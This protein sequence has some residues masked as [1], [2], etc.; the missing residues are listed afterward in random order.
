MAKAYTGPVCY[1]DGW[2]WTATPAGPGERLVLEDDGSYRLATAADQSW[3]D[4]H[5]CECCGEPLV[6][7]DGGA[8]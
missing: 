5:H 6:G 4:R 8:E 3:H 7:R 2:H 1:Q